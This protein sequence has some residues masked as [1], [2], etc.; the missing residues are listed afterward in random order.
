MK[1]Y[2]QIAKLMFTA[3]KKLLGRCLL[4]VA[5]VLGLES[6]IPIYMEWM[7][8]QTEVR[9][10]VSLFA[11]YVV[12]FIAAYLAVCI[13]SAVR[14]GLYDRLGQY[15]MWRT[16][17]KIYHVLWSSDYST[18]VRDNREKLK[19]VLSTE[20]FNV[21]VITTVYTV[22]IV[23]DL[24]TVFLFLAL[25]FYINPV[26]A[27]VLLLSI[28]AT[29]ALSFHSGKKRL[30]N[31]DKYE[32]AK[33]EDVI[34]NHETV[35][36]TE[37]IRTNGLASYYLKRNKDSLNRFFEVAMKA[38]T[39]DAFWMELDNAI[40]YIVFIMVA[41]VLVLT[42]STGGQ[43]VA[44]LFIAN[45]VLQ[46][47]QSL[48]RQVQVLIKNL[49]S[50]NKVMEVMEIPVKSGVSVGKISSIV[51]HAVSLKYPNGRDVFSNLSF[52]LKTGDHVLV[53]GVNGSGKSS[54][55]RMIVGLLSPTEGTIAINGR[56]YID[57]DQ[58]ELY[59]EICYISQDELFLNETVEDYL[60]IISHADVTED[61]ITDLREKMHFSAEI[62]RITDNGMH[63][64]GGEKKKLLLLKCMLRSSVSV[65][66]LDE[67][68]SGL[69]NETKELLCDI[70]RD[71]LSDPTK[72]VI[73]ISHIQKDRHGFNK[74]IQI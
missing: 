51:F 42:G 72:I 20:T 54:V 11:G 67:I 53:E 69:D 32:N 25:S 4:V 60:R 57:Y 38:D 66:I 30:L 12:I 58:G 26:V 27:V 5:I 14:T 36:M 23:I 65:I 52:C 46:R 73:K 70:E 37:V 39:T 24:F 50:F 48:Q 8:D 7:I 44:A 9:K 43:L 29:F 2:F 13:L 28:L 45:Y 61:Y 55:L 40:H 33:E 21:Y 17:E 18:F 64:S 59:K 16:R 41:G 34:M 35:D 6:V 74:I 31:F 71:I 62:D 63:L 56:N 22:G 19:F 1:S 10:S 15:I 3:D 68:D 49:P 47:S